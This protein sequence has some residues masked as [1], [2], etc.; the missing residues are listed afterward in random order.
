[1]VPWYGVIGAPL[2]EGS[3]ILDVSR[4]RGISFSFSPGEGDVDG[5]GER[6]IDG[7]R[8]CP[9]RLRAGCSG[10]SVICSPSTLFGAGAAT[11]A[12]GVDILDG[13][14]SNPGLIISVTVSPSLIVY[15]CRSLLS[16]RAFP[17]SSSRCAS[18]GGA[19]GS[20]ASCALMSEIVS[21]GCTASAKL[22][23]G[24][25]DLKVMLSEPVRGLV[26]IG[27]RSGCWSLPVSAASVTLRS[28]GGGS[29]A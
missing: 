21:V 4:R 22:F 17:L 19:P 7:V 14:Q 16:A 20:D 27:D 29:S 13:S 25:I 12:R 11:D 6:T 8:P 23:G 24:L 26:L 1:M 5:D 18:A 28:G 3:G 10:S 9:P 15:S 2:F